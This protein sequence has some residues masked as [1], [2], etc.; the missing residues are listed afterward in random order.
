MKRVRQRDTH[1]F[2]K[3]V[4]NWDQKSYA[5]TLRHQAH[6]NELRKK[7]EK[8]KELYIEKQMLNQNQDRYKLYQQRYEAEA[9][10]LRQNIQNMLARQKEKM[11]AELEQEQND[12]EEQAA[13]EALEAERAYQEAVSVS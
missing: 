5:E 2:P 12:L 11:D 4:F 13:L 10:Q 6:A 9:D 8:M 7:L 1:L 3:P